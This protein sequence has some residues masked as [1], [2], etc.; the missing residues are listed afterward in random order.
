MD[1]EKISSVSWLKATS[2]P[3][4]LPEVEGALAADQSISTQTQ[5]E[6][7][8]IPVAF[9]LYDF[10]MHTFVNCG[11]EGSRGPT[12]EQCLLFYSGSP[13]LETFD[14]TDTG[15]QIWTVPR[16]GMYRITC[17]GAQSNSRGGYGAIMRGDFVLRRGEQLRILVGQMPTAGFGG[18]GGSFV[19]RNLGLE[20]AD[21]LVAAGGGGGINGSRAN[22]EI[23]L[24]RLETPEFPGARGNDASHGSR[25][26][27]G[28]AGFLEN[29][30]QYRD[31]QATRPAEGGLGGAHGG[32]GGGGWN[33]GGTAAG[34]GGGVT[35]GNASVSRSATNQHAAASGGYSYNVGTNQQNEVGNEGQ[36]SV[37][38]EFLNA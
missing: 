36:G 28:G 6:H 38:V 7:S 3:K 19:Y 23:T 14:V 37:R 17:C 33:Q 10:N 1:I 2:L 15:I 31:N 21:L 29:S 25:R 4:E 11:A 13:L 26:G 9:T 20:L 32:F 34:G 8:Q 12:L 5:G 27:F 35:G 30:T 16:R 24:G 18:A 22:P